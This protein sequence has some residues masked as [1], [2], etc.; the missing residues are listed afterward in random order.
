MER[1]ELEQW[2]YEI[3]S[4]GRVRYLV[5]PQTSTVILVYAS[6]PS[7]LSLGER[8]VRDEF[9]TGQLQQSAHPVPSATVR[10]VS[11]EGESDNPV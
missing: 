9:G 7:R 2:E 8:L 1:P 10:G 5:S 3:T 6:P 4:G 11:P